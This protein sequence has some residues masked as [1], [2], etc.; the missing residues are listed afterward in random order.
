[1]HRSEVGLFLS[2]NPHREVREPWRGA[3]EGDAWVLA[4]MLAMPCHPPSLSSSCFLVLFQEHGGATMA[5]PR[6]TPT[7]CKVHLPLAWIRT[8]PSFRASSSY[9]TA[10]CRPHSIHR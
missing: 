6:R 1:M 9:A 5:P 3:L 2:S 8:P 10:L 7:P 4:A